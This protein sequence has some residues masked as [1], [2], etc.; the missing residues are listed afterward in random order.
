M[1][2][3][4]DYNRARDE[5]LSW[6]RATLQGPKDGPEEVLSRSP[7]ECYSSGILVPVAARASPDDD[8]TASDEQADHAMD[9]SAKLTTEQSEETPVDE[10]RSQIMPTSAVGLSFLVT[11][12]IRLEVL[13]EGARYT[14]DN[15]QPGAKRTWRRTAVATQPGTCEF[16]PPAQPATVTTPVLNGGA[17]VS[18]RWR[19]HQS[20]WLVTVA[21]V[22]RLRHL[23]ACGNV[24]EREIFPFP[25]QP[26]IRKQFYSDR[27]Q[28]YLKYMKTEYSW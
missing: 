8:D 27:L 2:N 10:H 12:D 7:L 23:H 3:P 20:N 19:A 1:A 25:H 9:D 4:V 26:S 6:M 17:E 24:L 22:N 15:T 16:I 5:W 21:L 14:L 11:P 18:V 28:A 13:V